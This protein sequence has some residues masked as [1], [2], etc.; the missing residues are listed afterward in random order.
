MLADASSLFWAVNPLLTQRPFHARL[1]PAGLAAGSRAGASASIRQGSTIQ[2]TGI[3]V[4]WDM[5]SQRTG[6]SWRG[7]ASSVRDSTAVTRI[8][9][10][11]NIGYFW[12][13]WMAV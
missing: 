13:I 11:A 4:A 10:R 7:Q 8:R 2:A 5:R 12:S 6:T 1:S 9:K 3:E